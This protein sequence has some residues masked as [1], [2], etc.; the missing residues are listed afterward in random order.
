MQAACL[1]HWVPAGAC[2][3]ARASA[4]RW[5]GRAEQRYSTSRPGR[6]AAQSGA[7]QNRDPFFARSVWVPDQQRSI[8]LH[9][10]PRRIRDT[11]A[12]LARMSPP[13]IPAQAGIQSFDADNVFVALGPRR[14]LSS[15]ARK[16]DP[17]AGTSGD[18]LV[19]RTR[20]SAKR[21]GAE[22]GPIRCEISV[23]PGSAAQHCA[24][25][26][27]AP[28]PGHERGYLARMSPPLIP[29]KAGIQSCNPDACCGP[30]VPAC[31]GTSEDGSCPK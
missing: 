2:H 11:R 5:R 20:C 28:H 21:C 6:D 15:G 1:W 23:G 7:S 24:S 29:A 10:M 3:R 22:P 13:L 12:Y 31:A 19:S 4:T 8:A 17:L 16:R 30:W 9:F 14:S 27:A 26:H 25:L 18:G